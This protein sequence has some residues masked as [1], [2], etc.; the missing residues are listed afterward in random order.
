MLYNSLMLQALE[1]FIN[2][3]LTHASINKLLQNFT[4]RKKEVFMKWRGKTDV[5]KIQ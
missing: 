5:W 4:L 1:H 3:H 2:H